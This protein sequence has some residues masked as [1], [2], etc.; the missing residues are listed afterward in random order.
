MI[1]STHDLY[2]AGIAAI[3][4]DL[5]SVRD[6]LFDDDR[7]TIRYLVVT[8]GVWLLSRKILITP[9]AIRS[10]NLENDRVEVSLTREQVK[11]S[12]DI[13]ADKPIS[14]Q[15]EATYLDY[16]GY[17]YYWVDPF[18]GG[19]APGGMVPPVV[20]ERVREARAREQENADPHLRSAKEVTGYRIEA[21]DGE[22]GHVDDFLFDDETW[23]LRYLVI[24]TRNWLPGKKVLIAPD[25]VESVSWADRNVTVDLTREAIRSSPPFE[26]HS[27]LSDDY[28]AELYR[29]YGRATHDFLQGRNVQDSASPRVR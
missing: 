14:R 7:W 8:T 16:Y 5:G 27:R 20:D 4:G 23:M 18:M 28:E 3:D 9:A 24:D 29:H 13:D 17:G 25:W 15:H 2:R 12:P 1:R 11:N 6:T 26:H 19:V 22:I 21:T 10:L